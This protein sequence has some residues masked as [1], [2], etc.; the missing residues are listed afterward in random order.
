MRC[1]SIYTAC[2]GLGLMLIVSACGMEPQA[3][4]NLNYK[5]VKTM[6]V[7]ILKTEEGK[8]AITEAQSGG[9]SGGGMKTQ[10]LNPQ[11][12]EQIKTA[13][14]D[15]LTSS[16]YK[17]VIEKVMKDPKFAGEFAKAINKENKN[18][19][20][21]LIKDPDYQKSVGDIMKS[22]EVM[23]AYMDVTKSPEYRK[24]LMAIMK[25]SMSSP[26]FKL[27]VMDLLTKVVQEELQPKKEGGQK[28]EGEGTSA[29][30]E[31]GSGKEEGGGESGQEQ[32]SS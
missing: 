17:D 25:E 14:K 20:K 29:K 1:K 22:P 13:V 21:D 30:E 3:S 24:Q 26:L 7:D 32:K 2:L 8:K 11:Q 15:T 28:T 9:S 27:E 10:A 12:E 16:E 5:E 23:K 31:G 18:L 19:H 6:V 4:S